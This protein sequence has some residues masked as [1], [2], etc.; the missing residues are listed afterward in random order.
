MG[1]DA[2]RKV[3]VF[4]GTGFLGRRI[5]RHFLDHGA[6]VRVVARHPQRS[7]AMFRDHPSPPE[8][9][10]ADVNDDASIRPAVSEAFAVVNAVSL[11]VEHGD[12]TFRSMHVEAA[13]RVAARAREAGVTRLAHVSGIGADP[14]SRSPYI[15]SRGQGEDAVRASFPG[16]IIIRPAVMFGPDDAF[17]TPLIALLRG[18]PVFPLFGRG[19]TALQPAHVDDVA[20]AVMRAVDSAP[21]NA[22]YEL[23]GPRIYTYRDLLQILA[24]H[25][26]I[27]RVFV[28]VPFA[29]W[30]ALAFGAEKLP[31]PP[32]TRNQVELM[33]IDTVTSPACPG[34]RD[35][36][37]EPRGIEAVLEQ[38][39]TA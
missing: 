39:A 12:R 37:I 10:A 29:I 38:Q 4:G 17:L 20:Q 8:F 35:L 23:G 32:I 9:V 34:F 16:A 14:R 2:A 19:R 26:G 25:L 6:A 3:A 15:R 13:A 27:R 5:V 18:L 30:Q 24:A 28:P 11:Y 1:G 21:S 33:V 7:E 22:A 36:A 31:R